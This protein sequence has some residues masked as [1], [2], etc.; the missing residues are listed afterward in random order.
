MQLTVLML[1]KVNTAKLILERNEREYAP[2]QKFKINF[3]QHGLS[4]LSSLYWMILLWHT[5][6]HIKDI[7]TVFLNLANINGWMFAQSLWEFMNINPFCACVKSSLWHVVDDTGCSELSH[8]G[9]RKECFLADANT[10]NFVSKTAF[11]EKF[12]SAFIF[13][14]KLFVCHFQMTSWS[15][16]TW[17][18]LDYFP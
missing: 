7:D 1:W 4:S 3:A 18:V 9:D 12:N 8:I 6:S 17:L 13:K 10:T 15:F 16:W 14:R 5:V 11:R 2:K